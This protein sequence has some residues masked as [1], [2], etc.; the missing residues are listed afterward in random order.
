LANDL[1]VIMGAS[2]VKGYLSQYLL[3]LREAGID[4][5]VEDLSRMSIPPLGGSLDIKVS[6]MRDLA[7][8]FSHYERIVFSD[9]FDVVFLGKR[10]DVIS[11]IPKDH[12]LWAAEKNCYPD[13]NIAPFIP[14]RTPWPFVNGGLLCGTPISV[15]EW[16]SNAETHPAYNPS[17][18]DQQ[19]NN[20]LLSEQSP[21]CVID[22]V[23]K[24]FFCIFGGYEELEF[25]N[26]SP[27]NSVYGTRPNF[28]HFN[29]HWNESEVWSKLQRSLI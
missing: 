25:D 28:L 8:R 27:V 14:K 7:I 20:I 11:K 4:S 13:Q 22:D 10:D 29:G 9:A 24:L 15:L 16:C 12:V 17:M 2:C 21:L 19:F 26:G 3:Q 5:H 18:L 1:I 23:T 6:Q